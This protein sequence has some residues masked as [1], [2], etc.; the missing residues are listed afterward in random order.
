[1]GCSEFRLGST[2]ADFKRK[3][4]REHLNSRYNKE[5]VRE[6]GPKLGPDENVGAVRLQ[7]RGFC[8]IR[9]SRQGGTRRGSQDYG[10]VAMGK[11]GRDHS[12]SNLSQQTG[13]EEGGKRWLRWSRESREI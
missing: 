13:L 9:K 1:V 12:G 11:E 3:E 10:G 4:K 7:G 6:A 8:V 2:I 5:S